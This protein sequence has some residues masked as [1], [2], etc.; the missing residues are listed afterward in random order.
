MNSRDVGITVKK[1]ITTMVEEIAIKEEM[2][3]IN[4]S[5]SEKKIV[6]GTQ[7]FNSN[8]QIIKEEVFVISDDKYIELVTKD[9]ALVTENELWNII[10][11]I[12]D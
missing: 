4:H 9:N 10:D 8:N 7:L 3:Y 5:I 1:Q 12:R 2:T 11:T 6:I